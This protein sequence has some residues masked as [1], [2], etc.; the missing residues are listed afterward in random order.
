MFDD[1][2]N[3]EQV[4][5]SAGQSEAGD[6][7]ESIAPIAFEPT[8]GVVGPGGFDRHRWLLIGSFTLLVLIGLSAWY[9]FSGSSV[10][11]RFEPEADFVELEGVM[12]D[13]EL[14][15]RR[16]LHTGEYT[17]RARLEGYR[18]FEQKITTEDELKHSR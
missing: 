16:L 18:E 9:I 14:D 11:I 7:F 17:L 6:A 10:L 15:G 5:E 4:D 1:H 3:P 8:G 13:L 2:D 12:L